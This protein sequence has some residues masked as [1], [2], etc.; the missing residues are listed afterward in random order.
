MVVTI[1]LGA[2]VLKVAQ[3]SLP[4]FAVD[5]VFAVLSFSFDWFG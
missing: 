1:K 3:A 4:V 2:F 5:V